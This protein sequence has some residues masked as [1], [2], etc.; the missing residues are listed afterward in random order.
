MKCV[1]AFFSAGDVAF[2]AHDDEDDN[3]EASNT[4]F[5]WCIRN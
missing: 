2:G 5:V 3:D 4:S 1:C